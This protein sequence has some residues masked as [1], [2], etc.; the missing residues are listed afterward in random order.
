MQP[1]APNPDALRAWFLGPRAENADLFERLAL[2]SLRDHVFWRRNH[3]PEDGFTIHE[4]DRRKPGY[5]A[6]VARLTEELLGLLAVLKRDVPF[7]SGR[8]LGHML[9]EQTL[10]AQI[11]YFAAMLYNPNN[12][13]SEVSPVTTRLELEAAAQLAAM[14]G[15]D[16]AT[17]WGHL[18]S[19]G[20][21]ANFEALWIARGVRYLPV[22][23]ALAAREL[24]VA[25]P[26]TTLAG[27]SADMREL[28]LWSLLNL[29]ANATLDAHRALFSL[30][31]RA[32]VAAAL[33]EH[34]LSAIGYQDYT[35]RLAESYADPLPAGV[36]LVPATAHYSWEKVVRALGIGA[37]RMVAVPVDAACRMDPE[38]LWRTLEECAASRRPVIA[39]IGVCG[40]TEEGA[41]DRLDL[42]ADLRVR[43]E[44]ELGLTFHLHADACFGGYA[45]AI[46]RGADG[47]RLTAHEIRLARSSAWPSD[48]WVA[49]ISALSR[50]DSVTIDPHK[51]GYVP[52]PAGALLLQDKRSRE[53]VSLEPPYLKPSEDEASVEERF[54]GRWI[55]EG[56]KPGAAAAAVWLSHR[57]VPLDERGY[58]LLIGKTIDGAHLLHRE[59]GG[60]GLHPFHAV[61]LP[62]PDLNVVNWVMAHPSVIT[63]EAINRLNE[64]IYAQL[65]PAAS[66]APYFITRTQL[67][68]PSHDGVV[69]PLLAALGVEHADWVKSGMVVLRVTVMD[70]FFGEGPPTPDHLHGFIVA[71]RSTATKVLATVGSR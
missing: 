65:S 37:R 36:V 66:D 39:L 41:V 59:L 14:I 23:L 42:I 63:L 29:R 16:P 3:H 64:G 48:A 33:D 67:T 69:V 70:P 2:E 50:A 30:A 13:V 55:L 38:A 44:E 6:A 28:P 7:F 31:P 9:G 22:A 57:V 25:L 27:E 35:L 26:V 17:S 61:R 53:L 43:A 5:D 34:S 8:Y 62:T 56:S 11:G 47:R 21:I 68:S 20:T 71:L 40:T 4:T 18:T 1:S 52:Y 60:A 15:Y 32:A 24:G 12:V 54:L 51:L 45:A 49:S 58:G 10:A 19:G 46:T